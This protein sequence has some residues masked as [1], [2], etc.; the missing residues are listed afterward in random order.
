M[1]NVDKAKAR[2]RGLL[3]A[4][5][6]VFAQKG[7]HEATIS[8]IAKEAGVSEATIYEYFSTKEGLLFAIPLETTRFGNERMERQLKMVRGA[9]NKLRAIVYLYLSFY[10]ENPDY[11][12]VIMLILKQNRKFREA[13]AARV[14]GEGWRGINQLIEEGVASGEFKPGL[15]SYLVRAVILGTIEH[16]VTNWLMTGRPED[17]LSVVDP[18]LDLVMEGIYRQ[19][20][21]GEQPDVPF[22]SR[23]RNS[24]GDRER[25]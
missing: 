20:G 22:W 12:A 9:A 19:P 18:L 23:W 16:V 24:T 2:E 25:Q 6:K 14:I 5:Q 1:G 4:A 11:A 13:D 10:Q 8:E 17:L 7:F 21:V 3:K 15:D